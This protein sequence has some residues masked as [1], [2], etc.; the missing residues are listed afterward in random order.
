MFWAS[1]LAAVRK[2]KAQGWLADGQHLAECGWDDRSCSRQASKPYLHLVPLSLR[3][4]YGA[5]QPAVFDVYKD[6]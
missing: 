5:D 3:K 6:V 1:H 4:V 2:A